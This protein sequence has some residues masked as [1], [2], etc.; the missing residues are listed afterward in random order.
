MPDEIV[1]SALKKAQRDEINVI[2]RSY[3]ELY[4]LAIA[5][6]YFET[7]IQKKIVRKNNRRAYL[8]TCILIAFKQVQIYGDFT[9]YTSYLFLQLREDMHR[10]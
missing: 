9:M 1:K 4:T 5:W 2:E 6:I 3:I 7:L 10:L 8:A